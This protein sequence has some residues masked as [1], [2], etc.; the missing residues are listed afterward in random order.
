M[1]LF[2]FVSLLL[3]QESTRPAKPPAK[4]P[5]EPELRKEL[6]AMVKT[7]QEA[8]FAMI[9]A[10]KAGKLKPGA[11]PEE[12]PELKAVRDIDQ[13]TCKRLKEIVLR[14]GWPT[15]SLVG[16]AGAHDAWLLVQHCDEDKPFQKECLALL[17]KAAAKGEASK[18]DLA[19]LTDRV[20][21]GEGK[22]QR[23]G[24]QTEV[25]DGKAMLRPTEEP[26]HLDARRAAVGLGPIKEY[27]EQI[28]KMYGPKKDK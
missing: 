17:E 19:Y 27:L 26:D 25:K 24:T 7:D 2:L 23:Y 6:A 16:E 12:V 15:V 8:R 4:E 13:K 28:E 10:M 21:V 20:L 18:R 5:T 1:T 3:A 11:K 14:H 22:P 9:E